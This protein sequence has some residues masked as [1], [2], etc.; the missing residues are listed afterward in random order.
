MNT[1]IEKVLAGEASLADIDDHIDLWHLSK[2]S[3]PLAAF[4]GMTAIEYD[5]WCSNPR[6]LKSIIDRHRKGAP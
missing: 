6:I 2:T 5:S 4:L 3:K 1:F